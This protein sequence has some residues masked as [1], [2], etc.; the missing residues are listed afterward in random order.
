MQNN[1][2]KNNR[3]IFKCSV[4]VNNK[5]IQSNIQ[6]AIAKFLLKTKLI[7]YDNDSN[8]SLVDNFVLKIKIKH[9]KMAKYILQ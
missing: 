5:H 4:N 9:L 1:I 3:N 8:A 6:L 7:W 2:I